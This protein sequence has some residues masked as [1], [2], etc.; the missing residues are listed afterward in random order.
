MSFLRQI[1]ER[2]NYASF[3]NEEDMM[4]DVEEESADKVQT[5][6]TDKKAFKKFC[7]LWLT[8]TAKT[9]KLSYLFDGTVAYSKMTE[10]ICELLLSGCQV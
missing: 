5:S 4:Q 8:R 6:H 10:E 7:L 3:V 9:Y 1:T 2:S